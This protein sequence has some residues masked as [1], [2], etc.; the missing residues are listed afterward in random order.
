VDIDIAPARLSG[1]DRERLRVL[2]VMAR[3]KIE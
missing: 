1:R 2:A 3:A